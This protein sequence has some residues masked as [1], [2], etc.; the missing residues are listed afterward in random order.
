MTDTPDRVVEAT[1]AL[2][3]RSGVAGAGINEVL[4]ES[5]APKGSL[6]HFFP[7]GKRQIVVEALALYGE[8]VARHI[9]D[10]L[11]RGRDPAGKVRAL[12]AA[13]A[14]RL[15]DAD[16]QRSCAAGAAALDLDA[17]LEEVRAMI[18]RDFSRWIDVIAENIAIGGDTAARRS[19]AGLVLTAIEGGYVRGRAEHSTRP[20]L[21]AGEWL[22]TL[23]VQAGGPSTQ[24]MNIQP[25]RPSRAGAGARARRRGA[26]R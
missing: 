7:G 22:A 6:Y 5:G 4:Q 25:A 10:A 26:T 18:V 8:R 21:E 3:R 14:A 17:D 13:V 15:E 23:A 16:F 19:F 2:L 11:Q 20:L 9:G 24:A 1:I 12:F